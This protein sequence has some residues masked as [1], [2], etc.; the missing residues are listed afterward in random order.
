MTI[1]TC[2]IQGCGF[3]TEDVEVIGAAAILNVHSH[4]HAA[5]LVPQGNSAQ[6][7][8]IRAPKL[9]DSTQLNHRGLERL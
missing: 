7:V 4:T 3:Q 8:S 2:P 5:A 9:K 1:L 6:T